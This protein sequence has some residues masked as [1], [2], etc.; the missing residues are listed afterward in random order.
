VG[1]LIGVFVAATGISLFALPAGILGSGFVEVFNERADN[2]SVVD[3]TDAEMLKQNR[4][5]GTDLDRD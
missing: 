3:Q 2:A 5:T 4:N 1:K